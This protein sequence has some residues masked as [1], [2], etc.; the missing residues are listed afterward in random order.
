MADYDLFELTGLPFDPPDKAAKKVSETIQNH[1]KKLNSELGTA[2]QQIDRDEINRKLAFL[3]KTAA[4]INNDGN[5]LSGAYDELAK[6]RTE[7]EIQNLGA[8]V[9]L[10]KQSGSRVITNG[11]IRA[12]RQK[13]KLSKEHVEDVFRKSGFS[14]SEVDPLKALPKF[15]T[16]AEKISTE[17]EALR[18]S[19]DPDPNAPDI[20]LVTDIYA[21]AAYMAREP[22]KAPSYRALP[23][24]ELVGLFDNYSKTLSTRT[25]NFGKLC[26]SLATSA[27][28]YIFNSEANRDAYNVYLKYYTPSLKQ[29]YASMSRVPKSDLIDPR[30][31]EECIKQI[32]AVFGDYDISL[33]IYNKEAGLKEEPYIPEKSKFHV[34]CH[35]CQNITEF[36]DVNEAKKTNRCAN[37]GRELYKPC[38]K[39]HKSVL[40][41]LDKCPE[42]GYLF[43]SAAMF[44]KYYSAAEQAFRKSDYESA[45]KYIY[46]AQ[47]ADPGEKRKTDD[48][49]ARIDAEEKKYE[50]PIND[51]RKLVADKNFQKASAMLAGIIEKYPGLDVS[52]HEKLIKAA[53][54]QARAAFMNAKKLTSSKQADECLAIL[55]ECNDFLP[56][57]NYLHSTAP[58]SCKNFSASIDVSSGYLN[59]SW[60]RSTEQGISYRLIRKLGKDI[61]SN[62]K[63]GEILADG[64]RETS[65]QDKNIIP[66]RWYSYAAFTSR[67]GVFSPAVGK[68]VVVKAEVAD[69][70]VDQNNKIIR[71]TWTAPKNSVGATIRRYVGVSSGAGGASGAGGTGGADN[72]LTT[73]AHG[74][75]EDKNVQYGTAYTYTISANYANMPS[76]A[77]VTVVV[78]PLPTIDSFTISETQIKDNT[79]KITWSITQKGIDLRLVYFNKKQ[80]EKMQANNYQANS[81]PNDPKEI[82]LKSDLGSYELTLP[83]NDF[84]VIGILAFSGGEWLPSENSVSVNTFAPCEID[85]A[86]SFVR[87]DELESRSRKPTY[88]VELHIK[89]KSD[90][91]PIAIVGF[92][93]AI[94]KGSSQNKWP[95]IDDIGP[96]ADIRRIELQT[97]LNYGEILYTETTS[98]EG[99]Y[100][101]SLFTIVNENGEEIITNPKR[102]RLDRPLVADIFWYIKKG[103][104]GDQTL[105][106]QIKANK[107]ISRIPKLVLCTS[108]NNQHLMSHND[109][110]VDHHFTLQGTDLQTPQATYNKV[111]E[112]KKVFSSKQLKNSKFFLFEAE[113]IYNEKFSIRRAGPEIIQDKHR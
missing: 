21:F 20:N 28:M 84:Y 41:T 4:D 13:T 63:D 100:Y 91:P 75:F 46:Q 74:S 101:V 16:N 110:R 6:K 19:K 85:K 86:A 26:A 80:I 34:M 54:N 29:L 1:I 52:S 68:A 36:S 58:E 96:A 32:S 33:A 56:A 88:K 5:K 27:K 105:Y 94:R 17:L 8:A 106:I 77:G 38:K 113:P 30:L 66:G 51:L 65:Y 90:V 81:Y 73:N 55:Q 89:I 31:A 57:I 37:C 18:K 15:P 12:Y 50:K 53:L 23:T 47:S 102:C 10:L 111:Y 7:Q 42:C 79:Y 40:A 49:I 2:T 9:M 82:K 11:T 109:P 14:I 95:S 60:S 93:Y 99:S 76:S 92:Y 104:F 61:P 103:I 43:A 39:C 87:E 108:V 25:D 112:L 78:T 48:F 70:R 22:E 98:D 69:V 35:H 44:V 107:P 59:V 97:Y 83:P 24:Q 72:I 67:Y 3:K 64:T 45:R 62:E 71:L